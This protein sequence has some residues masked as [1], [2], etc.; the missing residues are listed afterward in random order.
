MV[1]ESAVSLTTAFFSWHGGGGS[2]LYSLFL[3]FHA[4]GV[5]LFDLATEDFFHSLLDLDLVGI[6]GD[7]EDVL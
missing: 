1:L 7:L 5:D 4:D 3:A 6:D 2:G